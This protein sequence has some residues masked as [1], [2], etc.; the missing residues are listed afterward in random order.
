MC[1]SD[2]SRGPQLYR[3]LNCGAVSELRAQKELT[4]LAEYLYQLE[5]EMQP[6]QERI[7]VKQP[8]APV[9]NTSLYSPCAQERFGQL[10]RLTQR[11]FGVQIVL[12]LLQDGNGQR[13]RYGI[14]PGSSEIGDDIDLF[15]LA[16]TGTDIFEVTDA[17][18]DAR[19]AKS[20]LVLARPGI[21]YYAGVPLVTE[22]QHRAGT[23]CLLGF[24]TRQLS[25]DERQSLT[26]LAGWAIAELGQLRLLRQ[27]QRLAEIVSQT[28]NG[29]IITDRSGAVEWI[30]DGFTSIAGYDLADL[31][32][33]KPGDLLQGPETDPETVR[34]MGSQLNSGEGFEVDIL[35]YHK[36]GRPYWLHISCSPL[37]DASGNVHGFMAI[38]TDITEK[39]QSARELQESRDM[40]HS[41][42][43][44]M[45]DA[46]VTTDK[47]GN[48]LSFN[49][50]AEKTFQYTAQ[51]IMGSRITKLMPGQFAASHDRHMEEY[52]R[53]G[54]G[55]DIMGRARELYGQRKNGEIFPLEAAITE[56][57]LSSQPIFVGLL[58]DVTERKAY[59]AQIE[60]LAFYDPLTG[61]ANRRL[62]R[63]RLDQCMAASERSGKFGAL[64]FLDLDNFKHINDTLGHDRGDQLL[65]QLAKTFSESLYETDSV[66][67]LGGDEF[68]IVLAE[69]SENEF[70]AA[71][72]A[73]Q[74]VRRLQEKVARPFGNTAFNHN[75]TCSIG[76][77]LFWGR[78]QSVNELMK[79]SD[80]AM[81][82]AKSAGRNTFC[83]FDPQMQESL[84]AFHQT[85]RDLENAIAR[86]EL[87]PFYQAQI[88][89]E[90]FLSGTELL[91]RWN[92][93][94]RGLLMPG[95]FIPIAE[96]SGLI[97]P[98]GY[99]ILEMA[100]AQLAAW[101]SRD[102]S[103]YLTVSVNISPRQFEQSDFVD[104]VAQII[105]DSGANPSL[106]RME[107]TESMLAKDIESISSKMLALK[108]FGIDF[109]LDDFGTGYSSLA[110]LKRLP[111]TQLKIDQSFVKDLVTDAEDRAIA[112]TIIALAGTL[113][114]TALAEGVETQAHQKLLNQMGCE[115]FQGY[116]FGK[117]EPLSVFEERLK[118]HTG[119]L[120][121]ISCFEMH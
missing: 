109:E 106:L 51:E 52:D 113:G 53:R 12:I 79:R 119:P 25:E 110:Y 108:A 6:T 80:I 81:Y 104:R 118:N 97:V 84:V 98:M 16:I 78:Q 45:H 59:E 29:V 13:L 5:L 95:D 66:A 14:G 64:L 61:L 49:K 34:Y 116:H 39:R 60:K 42:V 23:L 3:F 55:G 18:K 48:I 77:T 85:E 107:I 72:R 43:D 28:T 93:P 65:V 50:A 75:V 8:L 67:R 38:Q 11:L 82:G 44:I 7:D 31:E 46:L 111:I 22:D 27:Q 40:A 24:R 32:G 83:F 120:G 17:R 54:R 112:E 86:E 10:A 90:G 2:I 35:N 15:D 73:E 30:N 87:V 103:K 33:R 62:I 1:L 89:R 88:N 37:R 70:R 74:V 114:M 9:G 100:C 117:P 56:T 101:S 91:I 96:S 58:R 102:A 121:R 26:D 57:S 47:F 99:Q 41:I 115:F 36:E 76:V 92:H 19:F 63:D 71:E 94:K 68:L 4:I 105:K 20:P 21:R 69:L